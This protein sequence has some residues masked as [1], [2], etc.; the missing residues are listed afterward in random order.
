MNLKCRPYVL[1]SQHKKPS[2]EE[3]KKPSKDLQNRNKIFKVIHTAQRP[4]MITK[5]SYKV[6]VKD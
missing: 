5:I 2:R 1:G 4:N 6:E 3:H